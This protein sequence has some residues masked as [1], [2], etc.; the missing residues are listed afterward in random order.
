M[1]IRLFGFADQ[2]V[3]LVPGKSGRARTQKLQ[4]TNCRCGYGSELNH[5]GTTA[6]SQFFHLPGCHSG[7]TLFL[8]TTA[9]S[10]STPLRLSVSSGNPWVGLWD[11]N[12]WSFWSR[13][14]FLLAPQTSN[15]GQNTSQRSRGTRTSALDI[16]ELASSLSL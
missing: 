2:E 11:L 16:D 12:P 1:R 6:F 8:T 15:P 3:Q 9:I 7:V 14:D 4:I 10:F 5:Q 13:W